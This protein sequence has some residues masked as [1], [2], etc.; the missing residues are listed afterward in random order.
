M[1]YH[2]ARAIFIICD[3]DGYVY[4]YTQNTVRFRPLE[5]L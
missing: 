3:G 5:L 4:I 2:E 1:L